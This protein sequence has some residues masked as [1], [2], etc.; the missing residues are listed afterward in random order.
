MEAK[1]TN[2][3]LNYYTEGSTIMIGDRLV[4]NPNEAQRRSEGYKE[5]IH[6]SGNGGVYETDEFII[7]E[8]PIQEV[9]VLSNEEM[10]EQAYATE[11]V[12]MWEGKLR[13]CDF[14]RGLIVTYQFLGSD[15]LEELKELWLEGRVV[16]K[17][18]WPETETLQ[19]DEEII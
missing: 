10:R 11:P 18:M 16:I 17:T 5:V 3:T 12:V 1:L 15:K 6:Q 2:N 8:T 9:V 19:T 4:T 14:I 7:I 13:T